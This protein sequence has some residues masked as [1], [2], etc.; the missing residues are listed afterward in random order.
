MR[1]LEQPMAGVY[2][3]EPEA[4]HDERGRFSR[5]FCVEELD[6]LDANTGIV[7]ANISHSH[8]CGTLRGLH[9]QHPPF[10]ETKYVQCVSGRI[11][12]VVLDLRPR[13]ATFRKWYAAGLDDRN[14]WIMVIPEGCAHGFMTLEEDCAVQYFVTAP[15]APQHEAG[16]RHDDPAFAIR[17][18]MAPRAISARDAS[19]PLF[20]ERVSPMGETCPA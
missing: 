7:Q 17:W 10:A 9:Y 14:G 3:L 13:S 20:D 1:V 16:V 8:R 6:R 4:H 12:D 15:H 5:C 18:P 19:H 11:H 2:L